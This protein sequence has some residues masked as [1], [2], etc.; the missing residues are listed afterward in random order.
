[1]TEDTTENKEKVYV[2]QKAITNFLKTNSG[3][4]SK[5]AIAGFANQLDPNEKTFQERAKEKKDKS[6]EP[7]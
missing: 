3:K 6:E 2:N 5:V 4:D 7:K 1:M